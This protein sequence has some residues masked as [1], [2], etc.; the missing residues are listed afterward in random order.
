MNSARLSGLDARAL[1]ALGA[2]R[3]ALRRHSPDAAIDAARSAAQIAP[4][5]PEVLRCLALALSAAGPSEEAVRL[6]ARAIELAPDD[7][8]LANAHA[9][10]LQANART[11]EAIA[12]LHRAHRLAP[13][14][15][16]IAG[17][18]A[19]LLAAGGA[20][21]AAVA[22]L[23]RVIAGQPRHRPTRVMLAELLLRLPGRASDS[24]A[25]L[26]ELVQANPDDAWA[27]SALAEIEQTRFGGADIAQL[28]RLSRSLQAGFEARVHAAFALARAREQADDCRG[29]FAEY[30]NANAAMHRRQHWNADEFSQAVSRNLAALQV[31][32]PAADPNLGTGVVFIVGLPRSGSSLI[33]QILASHPGVCAGGERT[34]VRSLIA[35]ESAR[36]RVDFAEWAAQAAAEDWQRLGMDYLQRV[37][38]MRGAAPVFTDKLPGNWVWLGAA[39]NMLPGARVIECR[40]QRLETAWACYRRLFSGGGQDFSYDFR[41]IAR[42][43]DDCER[44]MQHWRRLYP[45]RIRSQHYE[46]LIADFE[47]QVRELLGF[48]ALD[49]DPACLAFHRNERAV[50]T[51]SASQVREPLRP[52]T[53]RTAL[54]GALLDPLRSA[55]GIPPFTESA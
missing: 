38:P 3:D 1:A 40:R 33:E 5:H 11:N 8:I 17:N 15:A 29:A 53:A 36:C 32:R 12:A 9:L 26:R 19:R 42:F 34:E 4:D 31:P 27:W 23:E 2:S 21:G 28:E 30:A 43:F 7:A 45:T 13:H 14:S 10:V 44:S 49:F 22:V 6:I 16:E 20:V 48:C 55:L 52:D 41:S 25:N 35:E 18:L 24:I 47:G 51:I 39:M 46:A 50:G 54:Y 37:A